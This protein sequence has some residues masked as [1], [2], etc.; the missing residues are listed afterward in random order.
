MSK[1]TRRGI[2]LGGAAGGVSLLLRGLATGLPPAFLANPR[3]AW[4]QEGGLAPQTLIFS[5]SELGD[6]VNCNA[7]GAYVEGA[8]HPNEALLPRGQ[9]RLGE[10]RVTGAQVWQSLP[11]PLRQRLAVFHLQTRS[12]AHP[13]QPATLN[14]HG[15]VKSAAGNGA[16][17]LPTM[18]AELA[19]PTL[20]TLQAEPV[21]QSKSD[22]TVA[23]QPLQLVKP[24]ELQALFADRD[25]QLA[26]MRASRDAAL[27]ALYADLRVDG[28]RAQRRFLDRFAQS[29]TQARAL[30]ERLSAL[31]ARLPLD[32]E[33]VDGAQDQVLAAVALAQ[34]RVAPVITLRL[35]FGGDNHND[36][37]LSVEAAETI[38]GVA[39]IGQL[40]Q[41]LLDAGL[42]DEVSFAMLNVFGRELV[43][44]NNGGRDH[45]NQHGVLLAFGP[46]F[47]GGVYGGVSVA[48][49]GLAIDPVTGEGRAN[50]PIPA[51]ETLEAAAKTLTRGLGHD[52]EII[53]Q[54]IQGGRI[55]DAALQV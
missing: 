33:D 49:G 53:A 23:G 39:R 10:A 51:S 43:R 20:N 17:M 40:W 50:A 6:P 11:N 13:E 34:L 35:P 2:L 26:D 38:S 27:D 24:S 16:E 18:I 31:L 45:N 54:R 7:P 21:R 25:A 47:R 3:R 12:V 41:G 14:C 55:I 32:P 15:S 30:G 1:P 19:A 8:Q 28:T 29:R 37:D 46:G 22:I 44:N 9:V 4:A 52:P 36:S 5:T 42:Q 48:R